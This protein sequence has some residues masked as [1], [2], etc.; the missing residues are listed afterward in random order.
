MGSKYKML[1]LKL[2]NSHFNKT[3]T[4]PQ[5]HRTT[6]KGQNAFS[7][8]AVLRTVGTPREAWRL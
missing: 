8:S 3:E 7:A 5:K 1:S 6:A 2:L 4:A